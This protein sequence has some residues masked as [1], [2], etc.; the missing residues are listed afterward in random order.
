MSRGVA[1]DLRMGVAGEMRALDASL[2][3]LDEAVAAAFGISRTDL[4]AMERVS[5]H[6]GATAGKLAEELNL[7]TGAV[8][9]LIDRM[10][11]AG[12]FQRNGDPRDRRKVVVGLTAK[13]RERERRAY[14]PLFRE[15]TAQF[16]RYSAQDLAVITDF[17]RQA[18]AAVDRAAAR[19]KGASGRA[20]LK[21]ER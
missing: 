16:D 18:R 20:K 4:R 5:R 19:V 8:T 9:G 12:Y 13:A 21:S 1:V 7:T 17:L 11:R 15:S 2:D 14:E 6:G 3:L 10:Q